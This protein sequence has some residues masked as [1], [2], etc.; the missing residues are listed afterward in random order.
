MR[1]KNLKKL[2]QQL[3]RVKDTCLQ[4]EHANLDLPHIKQVIDESLHES[5][6]GQGE[7][8]VSAH[9]NNVRVS[10]VKGQQCQYKIDEVKDGGERGAHFVTHG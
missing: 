4:S 7:P 2:T 3:V 1:L 6:L 8:Q 9:L 10:A 5:D